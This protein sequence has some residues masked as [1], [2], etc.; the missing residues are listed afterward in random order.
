MGFDLSG[1]I[2]GAAEWF[3]CAPVVRSVV[4]NPIFT[5]LL[6]TALAFIIIM[7]L[8]HYPIKRAGVRRGLRAGLYVFLAVAA[9]IFVHHY[10][11]M[12]SAQQ[13]AA[14]KGIRDVFAGVEQ[15]RT[16]AAGTPVIPSYAGSWAERA[17][18]VSPTLPVPAPAA[19]PR[20]LPEQQT[21][22]AVGGCC[23]PEGPGMPYARPPLLGRTAGG[24]PDNVA[25]DPDLVIR[26][27]IIPSAAGPLGA[28]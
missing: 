21:P 9:I 11:V 26:D 10:A 22:G 5:A 28:T 24:R 3:C 4:N 16:S 23:S 1:A 14:Q 6:I 15:S 12:R 17:P 25:L 8:Y 20:P 7:A 18:V 19:Q 13:A 27:A 2:N